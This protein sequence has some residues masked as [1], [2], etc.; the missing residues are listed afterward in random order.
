MVSSLQSLVLYS[1]PIAILFD[2]LK[3]LHRLPMGHEC[4]QALFRRSTHEQL[5]DLAKT[6]PWERWDHPVARKLDHEVHR[7]RMAGESHLLLFFSLLGCGFSLYPLFSWF[8]EVFPGF[9]FLR[10]VLWPVHLC[11]CPRRARLNW[12]ARFWVPTCSCW[13]FLLDSLDFVENQ[14]VCHIYQWVAHPTHGGVCNHC[15]RMMEGLRLDDVIVGNR[16]GS[17]TEDDIVEYVQN[18]DPNDRD[19]DDLPLRMTFRINSFLRAQ[20]PVG[21]PDLAALGF[22]D[23]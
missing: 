8:I 10:Q 9:D 13:F 7:R 1:V 23:D 18:G 6:L 16:E 20:G 3:M 4:L 5:M 14:P 17:L 11:L 19:W 15:E 12:A 21:E 22:L 2:M